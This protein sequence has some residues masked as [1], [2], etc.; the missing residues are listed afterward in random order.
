MRV[1]AAGSALA[2]ILTSGCAPMWGTYS[3][4]D[5]PDARYFRQDC[6][7]TVGPR[8]IAYFPY[9][10]IF[11]SI[12]MNPW[13]RFGI[14]VPSGNDAELL[15]RTVKITGSTQSGPVEFTADIKPT[16]IGSFGSDTPYE[17]M[18]FYARTYRDVADNYFGPFKGASKGNRHIWHLFTAFDESQKPRRVVQVPR[19]LVSGTIEL[20]AL[21]VNGQRFEPQKLPFRR[22]SYFQIV[23]INC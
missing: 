6:R 12:D 22:D 8:S 11:I 17:F 13:I 1:A 3:R 10:G 19:G 4:I 2:L 16:S 15:G 23:P 14:H 21:A 18:A 7:G 9:H 5:A 20:P